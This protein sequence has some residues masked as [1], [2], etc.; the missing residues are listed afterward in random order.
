M[1]LV[2]T[3]DSPWTV[4]LQL[5]PSYLYLYLCTGSVVYHCGKQD[6]GRSSLLV[7]ASASMRSNFNLLFFKQLF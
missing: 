3:Q 4:L 7:H 1:W 5:P 6:N 2:F